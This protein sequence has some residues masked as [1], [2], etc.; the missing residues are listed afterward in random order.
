MLFSGLRAVAGSVLLVL[1]AAAPAAA[2]TGAQQD[3]PSW[4]L[5]RIDQRDKA[6]DHVYHYD[7]TGE[8][9]T[10]YVID[11]GV[12]AALADLSGRVGPGRNLVDGTDNAADGNG[13]GTRMAGLVAGTRYGVAKAARIVPVKVLDNAGNGRL[14][15]IVSGVDW[16]SQNAQQPAVAVIGFGGPASD[17][18]DNA[19][20]R[21]AGTMPVVAAA[22]WSGVDSSFSSPARIPE[23]LTVGAV[24]QADAFAPKSNSGQGVDL[25]A[26]GV[27]VPSTAPGSTSASP[28][29]GTSMSAALVAGAAALYRAQHPEATPQQVTDALIRNATP[30]VLTGVPQ[31]TPNRLLYTRSGAPAAAG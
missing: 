13:D 16:V 5:D 18:L 20:R 22:G 28:F 7:S 4:A 17:A 15:N 31:G 26:P 19:V 12:D 14:N 24:D 21:L 27:D 10:V 6:A 25:L 3:P 9:V 8:G 1:A 2:A 11:T 29:S 30:D 23:I